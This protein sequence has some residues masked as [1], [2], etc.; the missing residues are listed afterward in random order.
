MPS[1]PYSRRVE[2]GGEP[3]RTGAGQPE[4]FRHV[5]DGDIEAFDL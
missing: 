2:P 5:F 3:A 1:V 4:V